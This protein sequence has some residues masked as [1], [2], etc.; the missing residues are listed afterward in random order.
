MRVDLNRPRFDQV[1]NGIPQGEA[2]IRRVP[3]VSM[4]VVEKI[5]FMPMRKWVWQRTN[6]REAQEQ[7]NLGEDGTQWFRQWGELP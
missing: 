1:L 6:L 3:S 5:R 4:E 2:T 7:R